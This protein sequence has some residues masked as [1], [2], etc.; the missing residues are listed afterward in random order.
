MLQFKVRSKSRPGE[1][2]TVTARR[3]GL[4]IIIT[5]TCEAA[6]SSQ[7]CGH[8]LNLLTDPNPLTDDARELRSWMPDSQL[9]PILAQIS[10]LE[11]EAAAIKTLLSGAKKTLGRALVGQ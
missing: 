8:R 9:P 10:K 7:W 6:Q 11:A 2:H 3:E 4:K 1:S 5:C